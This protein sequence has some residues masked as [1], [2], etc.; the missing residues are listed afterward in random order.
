MGY[1]WLI[2]FSSMALAFWFAMTL[3]YDGDEVTKTIK[4][5]AN[6]KWWSFLRNLLDFGAQ[7]SNEDQMDI[8][9]NRST[10]QKALCLSNLSKHRNKDV[11]FCLKFVHWLIDRI[12]LP[13]KSCQ[14]FSAAWHGWVASKGVFLLF[15]TFFEASNIT[16]KMPCEKTL[17]DGFHYQ[18]IF[19]RILCNAEVELQVCWLWVSWL[20]TLALDLLALLQRRHMSCRKDDSQPSSC[21]DDS[22]TR[23]QWLVSS[24]LSGPKIF[25][26]FFLRFSVSWMFG[27]N[28]GEARFRNPTK[29]LGRVQQAYVTYVFVLFK[30]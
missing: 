28:L 29:H 3:M 27:R 2:Y 21:V 6:Q 14:P 9:V 16:V 13:A 15:L 19:S 5:F 17:V 22:L 4:R 12:S 23:R 8:R 30:S 18:I 7:K 26:I 10:N 20:V 11:N 25:Q 24:M 1:I